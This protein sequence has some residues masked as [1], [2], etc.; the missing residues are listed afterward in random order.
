MNL[1]SKLKKLFFVSSLLV[2]NFA[3]ADQ[4]L[5]PPFAA[6]AKTTARVATVSADLQ[7]MPNFSKAN[8]N[9]VLL[10]FTWESVQPEITSSAINP[11]V[12]IDFSKNAAK[13][14]KENAQRIVDQ[15]LVA[16]LDLHNYLSVPAGSASSQ[17]NKVIGK[18]ISTNQYAD[19]WRQIA[20]EFV[21]PEYKN[22]IALN[23]MDAKFGSADIHIDSATL[24]DDYRHAISAIRAT[25]FAGYILVAGNNLSNPQFWD[26]NTLESNAKWFADINNW[27]PMHKIAINVYVGPDLNSINLNGFVYWAQNTKAK[28]F[29]TLPHNDT[30]IDKQSCV[31]FFKQL[32]N[33]L[34]TESS[35]SGGFLGVIS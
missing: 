33:S 10:P 32:D 16:I 23:L 3:Y 6:F 15:G 17:A 35:V 31:N 14:L 22:R 28:V 18:D 8:I 30:K 9:A 2:A 4:N 27:D 11:T 7:S 12:E 13:A 25:G 21:K 24:V 34:V 1:D 19:F 26:D 5:E 29:L 20:A